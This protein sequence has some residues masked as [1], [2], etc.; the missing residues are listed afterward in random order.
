MTDQ[1]YIDEESDYDRE[2]LRVGLKE[3]LAL[4]FSSA[5]GVKVW[6]ILNDFNHPHVGAASGLGCAMGGFLGYVVGSDK[7]VPEGHNKRVKNIPHGI[8]GM[9]IGGLIG[10]ATPVGLKAAFVGAEQVINQASEEMASFVNSPQVSIS[11]RQVPSLNY[12]HK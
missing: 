6:N 1:N 10:T 11:D 7:G 4:T 3:M 2:V 8:A 12:G 9:V 5:V